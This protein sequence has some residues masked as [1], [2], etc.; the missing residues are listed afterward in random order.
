MV[1]TFG[2]QADVEFWKGRELPLRQLIGLDGR[3]RAV[4]FGESPF[5]SADAERARAAWA[6]L[7]G[8]TVKQ[9]QAKSVELLRAAGALAAEPRAITHAVKF[10]ERGT[11]PAR[12]RADPPV[13]RA[14]ARPPARVHRAGPQ[15]RVAPGVHARALRE[16]GRGPEPGLV[17]Q[18]PALLRRALPGLVPARPR[19][20]RPTTTRPIWAA[21]E[22]LPIDPL[23]VGAPGLHRGAAGQAGRLRGRSRRDGHLG[24][25]VAH[26]ADRESLAARR[27]APPER[28]PVRHAPA[29]ARDHPHL[30][31]LHDR[32][33]VDARARDPLAQRGDLR[34]DP[35]PRPQEDVEVE[36]Q[37]G[38]ADGALRHALGRRRAL[39]GRARAARRRHGARRA[40]HEARPA[41]R[42]QARQRGALRAAA[43]RARGRER[44]VA[45][46]GAH[47]ATRST[48]TSR[49]GSR[50]WSSARRRR[51]ATSTSP[52]RCT[53]AKRPSGTSA[54]T[55]SRS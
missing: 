2:D 3:M 28:V 20:A 50:S 11:P 9:A 32:E 12:V 33:G 31:L 46:R 53:P 17:R 34:L 35:R 15:D 49:R 8:K 44:G 41:A 19:R 52:R 4:R 24:D 45:R 47:R 48:S 37:R 13:V 16:L 1:C 38:H 25:V 40:G 55:T 6:E 36:G 5:E 26:A 30:G 10:Y 7:E 14:R 29:G 42:D 54:T 18:P 51:S 22:S 27:E 39:L 21:P 23:A 43:A